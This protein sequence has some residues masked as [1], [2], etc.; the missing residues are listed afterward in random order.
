MTNCTEV[1]N[2][3][4]FLA[5]LKVAH[6]TTGLPGRPGRRKTNLRLFK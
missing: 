2:R 5:S 1:S 3:K 6:V 4:M